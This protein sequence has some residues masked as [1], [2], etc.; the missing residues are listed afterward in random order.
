MSRSIHVTLKNFKGLTK[1]QIDEQA[2]ETNSD[3]KQW[4]EK[5]RIKK[6]VNKKRKQEKAIKKII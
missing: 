1:R 2:T 6:G 5:K 4:V 3:L